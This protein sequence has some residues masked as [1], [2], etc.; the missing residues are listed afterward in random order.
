MSILLTLFV[1]VGFLVV[2]ACGYWVLSGTALEGSFRIQA[3]N[4]KTC[5]KCGATLD[6]NS[7]QCPKCFLRVSV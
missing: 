7:D 1:I 3:P 4:L 6:P 5:P 2:L